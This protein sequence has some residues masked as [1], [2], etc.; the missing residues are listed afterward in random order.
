[1]DEKA[2]S[3]FRLMRRNFE[4]ATGRY[5]EVVSDTCGNLLVTVWTA[6][7]CPGLLTCDL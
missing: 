3:G 4:A 7:I 1:M 2:V 5:P 6:K